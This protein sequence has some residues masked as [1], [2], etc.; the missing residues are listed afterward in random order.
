MEYL[1][2]T[3]FRLK[4]IKFVVNFQKSGLSWVTA[5]YNF[6]RGIPPKTEI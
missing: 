3:E 4:I 2:K 5:G 6:L 1:A